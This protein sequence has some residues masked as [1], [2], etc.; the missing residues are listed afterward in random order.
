MASFSTSLAPYHVFG[1]NPCIRKHVFPVHHDILLYIAGRYLV[2]LNIETGQRVFAFNHHERQKAY[3]CLTVHEQTVYISEMGHDC[4]ILLCNLKDLNVV[5]KLEARSNV[6]YNCL[7]VR[8]DG[9]LL[10]GVTIDGHLTLW[11][12]CKM[13]IVTQTKACDENVLHGAFSLCDENM[14]MTAG[15]NHLKMWRV[16]ETFTGLKLKGKHWKFGDTDVCNIPCY[17]QLQNGEILT[18]TESGLLLL[19]IESR[20]K[21]IFSLHE[22]D[23]TN[24]VDKTASDRLIPLHDGGVSCLHYDKKRHEIITGGADGMLKWWKSD[25]I[26][27]CHVASPPHNS[28][29]KYLKLIAEKVMTLHQQCV[30]K[31]EFARPSGDDGMIVKDNVGKLF[32]LNLVDKSAVTYVDFHQGEISGMDISPT[33]HI[34]VTGGK[35][36]KICCFQYVQ[37]KILSS[38]L[39]SSECTCITWCPISVDRLATRTFVV[40]FADGG[41]QIMQLVNDRIELIESF[42]P[43]DSRI[44]VIKFHSTH[45][46]FACCDDSGKI[47]LFEY[48]IT[49]NARINPLPVG[50][51]ECKGM[52]KSSFWWKEDEFT[53]QYF[54]DNGKLYSADL[55][56]VL[57]A[58]NLSKR[59][60]YKLDTPLTQEEVTQNPHSNSIGSSSFKETLCKDSF[61]GQFVLETG[62]VGIVKIWQSGI[63][64]NNLRK[65]TNQQPNLRVFGVEESFTHILHTDNRV[66]KSATFPGSC[67]ENL[68]LEQELKQQQTKS[69]QQIMS[70]QKKRL[71]DTVLRMRTEMLSVRQLNSTLMPHIR[72]TQS[73]FFLH[74]FFTSVYEKLMQKELKK[75]NAN[76]H[77]FIKNIGERRHTLQETFLNCLDDDFVNTSS[78]QRSHEVR[79]VPIMK[80]NTFLMKLKEIK[81]RTKMYNYGRKSD[82]TPLSDEIKAFQKDRDNSP[83]ESFQSEQLHRTAMNRKVR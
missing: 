9:R 37:K 78:F 48:N 49:D 82:Y 19:W 6:G 41:L 46:T 42:Q 29:S 81:K 64:S 69:K 59:T 30:H 5:G 56:C 11:D 18:G 72:L 63:D 13:Q 67:T 22:N 32:K 53:L 16:E 79:C 12:L 23:D 8:N 77:D 52:L 20:I 45:C 26:L 62:P 14:I 17:I 33:E 66:E 27:L 25:S 61:D 35:D 60:T 73:E 58:R 34:C 50:F 28:K 39:L 80:R 4:S 65:S 38:I 2:K 40:G 3:S 55:R 47:F 51:I 10:C 54:S 68:T 76:N 21:Y 15:T 75:I 36:K 74:S 71:R 1:L 57:G 7:D 24:D 44:E 83:K 43:Y 70:K 31:I